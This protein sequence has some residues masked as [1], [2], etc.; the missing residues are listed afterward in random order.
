MDGLEEG[1]DLGIGRWN[2]VD[3]GCWSWM[4][5]GLRAFIGVLEQRKEDDVYD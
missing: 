5:Q 1:D 4:D 3:S 2:G